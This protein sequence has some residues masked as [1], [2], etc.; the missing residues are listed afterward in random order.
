MTQLSDAYI[1]NYE[2]IQYITRK[3]IYPSVGLPNLELS[4]FYNGAQNFP[5]ITY[6]NVWI[7]F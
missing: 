2:A 1:S 3:R 6:V 5:G 7:F 4:S